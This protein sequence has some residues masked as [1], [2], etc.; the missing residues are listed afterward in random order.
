MIAYADQF[1]VMSGF[2]QVH[3]CSYSNFEAFVLCLRSSICM[4]SIGQQSRQLHSLNP[5]N[6]KGIHLWSHYWLS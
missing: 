6:N 3:P 1:I 2:P 4:I 5:V